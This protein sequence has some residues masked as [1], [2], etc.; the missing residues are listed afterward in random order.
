MND[1]RDFDRAVDLWLDDGSDATPPEVIDA[2]LLAVRS[3]PREWDFRI[4]WRTSPMKRL[5]YAI[6]A[7][8]ALAV[9]ATAFSALSPRFGIG[10]SPTP[11][12]TIQGFSRFN[13]T[14][15]GI[16]IDY[17]SD[18]QVRPA[19]EPWTGGEL[20]FDSPAADVIFDPILGDRLYIALASQPRPGA[21]QSDQFDLIEESGICDA[22]GGGG[23]GS[24]PPVDGASA[25]H[26]HCDP[27][28][29]SATFITSA[30][31][32]TEN[33]GYL[34]VLVV[35][36]NEPALGRTYDFGAALQTVDL[37]PDEAR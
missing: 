2:V 26:W 22:V 36:G 37:R 24:F 25:W 16:S 1:K 9:S 21:T 23:G 17:P 10:S 13:S 12:A 3:T 11:T 32:T 18:W 33:R 35:A 28:I 14:V 31:V 34:I 30:A 6:A 7:V 15:H 8:A 29:S 4:P 5:A 27:G 19:T 20:N